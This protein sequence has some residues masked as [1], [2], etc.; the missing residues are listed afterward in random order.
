[1]NTSNMDVVN[2]KAIVNQ[3]MGFKLSRSKKE[4]RNAR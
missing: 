3:R 4:L 1:M 2:S